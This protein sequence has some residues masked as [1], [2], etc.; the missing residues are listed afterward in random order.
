[1]ELCNGVSNG[2]PGDAKIADDTPC[3]G[4][5]NNTCLN[6]CQAG[7]CSAD[8]VAH[9]CG[10]G[11]LELAELCDDGNQ[12]NDDGCS[13]HCGLDVDAFQCYGTVR[14][15]Q[16]PVLAPVTLVDQFNAS[17]DPAATA[18]VGRPKDHCNPTSINGQHPE[19]VT[20]P[21]HLQAYKIAV[22]QRR[23]ISDL[24]PQRDVVVVNQYGAMHL[25]VTWPFRLMVP[26]TVSQSGSPPVVVSP[27]VDHFT[28]YKVKRSAGQPK[29]T[30]VPNQ[31]IA[32]QFGTR[33]VTLV[34]P[35]RLC[36]PTNKNNE[37][38]GAETNI[39]HLLCYRVRHNKF[40]SPGQFYIN[41]QFGI[42]TIV[43]S[44]LTELCIPS[45]KDP[46]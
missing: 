18:K 7:L 4:P 32:D 25:D 1:V 19:A 35:T 16:S 41:N 42:G 2:C 15:G 14:P 3:F 34:K 24:F 29:F 46:S 27:D 8:F 21:D 30:P 43:P 17:L 23:D 44:V 33:T 10:N 11:T 28:C 6:T 13:D 22:Q 31:I 38:P 37:E 45:V 20:A 12:A 5:N 36:L 26:T 9:C 40:D 39:G